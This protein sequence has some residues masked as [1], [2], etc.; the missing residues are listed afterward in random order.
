MEEL[1]QIFEYI[2]REASYDGK[3]P[4]LKWDLNE[5]SL[6]GLIDAFQS[7]TFFV[8][9]RFESESR[10]QI[11]QFWNINLAVGMQGKNCWVQI[12]WIEIKSKS[13]E[14]KFNGLNS[15]LS[16]LNILDFRGLCY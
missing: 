16:I 9:Q 12:Q 2:T 8:G 15:I 14:F 10:F 1:I 3:S 7:I 11:Y 6:W 13:A 4:I 5:A